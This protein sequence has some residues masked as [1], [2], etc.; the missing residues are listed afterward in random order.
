[1]LR[2]VLSTGLQSF[3]IHILFTAAPCTTKS[4]IIWR[5][6]E[7]EWLHWGKLVTPYNNGSQLDQL[8]RFCDDLAN[9]VA[10]A[11][12]SGERVAIV[13]GDHSCAIGTWR[14]VAREAGAVGLIWLDAHMDAHTR[15]SSPSGCWHGMPVANLLG[16]EGAQMNGDSRVISPQNLTLIGVRSYESE[17]KE[18]LHSLGVKV[19]TDNDVHRVGFASA[20][21]E[22][23]CRAKAGT[24]GYGI[25]IDLDGF[26]L[27][28][29]P[30]VGSPV[31]GGL[32][33]AELLEILFLL[34]DDPALLALEIAEFNPV[35]DVEKRTQKLL[36]NI[37]E[38]LTGVIRE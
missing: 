24:A 14:G 22:A 27:A 2:M 23:L 26:S 36:M 11:R 33:A 21:D 17:E 15:Y 19:F 35:V 5:S 13:G 31:V 29:A 12:D 25:S 38:K 18:L 32:K 37:L 30:G 6:L 7:N 20:M 16:C 10:D 1:A 28:D 4:Y 3:A 9:A 8:Q 34:K